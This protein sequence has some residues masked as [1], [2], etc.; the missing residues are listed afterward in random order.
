[1]WANPEYFGSSSNQSADAW[2]P[3]YDGVLVDK[4]GFEINGYDQVFE[5]SPDM[6]GK[7]SLRDLV[8][9]EESVAYTPTVQGQLD[10]FNLKLASA[11]LAYCTNFGTNPIVLNNQQYHNCHALVRIGAPLANAVRTGM[12]KLQ[13]GEKCI[14]PNLNFTGNLELN[15]EL[16][17]WDGCTEDWHRFTYRA[18]GTF[19][20]SGATV[21]W[22]CLGL[23][24]DVPA[25]GTRVVIKYCTSAAKFTWRSDGV[26]TLNDNS[27]LCW[28]IEGHST[29]PSN[30]MRLQ[31]SDGCDYE[32]NSVSQFRMF[33]NVMESSCGQTEAAEGVGIYNGCNR[34]SLSAGRMTSD[35]L[36]F[37]PAAVWVYGKPKCHPTT[38]SGCNAAIGYCT[39]KHGY[40]GAACEYQCPDGRYG[41][42]C[43]DICQC[44]N[45]ALVNE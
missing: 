13:M 7:Y 17:A 9:R 3:A 22:W 11:P 20:H 34:K 33:S 45:G 40:F 29:T 27:S 43:R 39:C 23:Q 21:N 24:D 12:F 19:K 18:D 10:P 31:L 41:R 5:L 15:T 38:S 14:R 42:N 1:M 32:S 44:K 6:Q 2:L 16:V 30:G 8:L 4:I 35:N 37:K 28:S 25:S 26:I 36:I